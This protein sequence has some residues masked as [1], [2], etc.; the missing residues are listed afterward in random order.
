M[1]IHKKP[2]NRS[3]T[4]G[5]IIFILLLCLLLSIA[6]LTLY[7][8]YVFDDY[9]GYI[10]DILNITL[11]QIDG[12]DLRTCIETGQKSEKYQ[13]TLLY[14]DNFMDHF[15]DIHYFYAVLPLNTEPIGNTM[16]VLSAERYY[17][18]YVD[19]EGNLYLGW[20]SDDEF[21]A[22]TAEQF[23]RILNGKGIVYFEDR[24][25]WGRDYT[26]AVPILDSQGQPVAVLALDID[27]SFLTD[28]ILQ[29][30][31]INICIIASLGAVFIAIFLFW[32][33]NNI[34]RPI[35]RLEQSAVGFADHSHGQRDLDALV[36]E[37]PEMTTDNEI[38]ALSDA[39]V[40]MTSDIR[41]YVNDIISAE[42]KA[43]TMK[44]LANRDALTGIRNKTAYD[45]DIRRLERQ[46]Q[47]GGTRIGLA[48]VDLND[49]KKINDTFGHDKGNLAIRKLSGMICSI[50]IHSR[51]YRIGGDEFVITLHGQDFDQFPQ[52]K[53]RFEAEIEALNRDD[54]LPP[55][56]GVSAAM[57]A[58]FFDESLDDGL[59]ALFNRADEVMYQRKKQMKAGKRES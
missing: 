30:A 53:A 15:S 19:T 54:S 16:S 36:F 9:R 45:H 11:D 50:F 43:E 10:A 2:L 51:V 56:E 52:L 46:L 38:K 32:S 8:N 7:R 44:K 40:K 25:E 21:S 13:E 22:E 27:I 48:I 23:F 34:T 20:I 12:D 59:D 57:G 37:A 42:E 29:Y 49:L 31:A 26:G 33:R 5:C 39:V 58:A 35:K 3:I 18:R 24:T 41:D 17:D 28:M 1:R 14:M 6:N 4:I 47:E 55:W